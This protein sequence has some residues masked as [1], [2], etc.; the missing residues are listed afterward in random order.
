MSIVLT[1]RRAAL[2]AIAALLAAPAAALAVTGAPT[3]LTA[4]TPTKVKPVLTWTA[5]AAPGAGIAGYNVYRG[6]TKVN[7]TVIATTTYTDNAATANTSPSYT[8]KAVE[9]GTN[10]ESAASAAFV[11]VYDTTI[12]T[13]PTG[14]SATTPTNAAPV[15][16]WTASTDALSGVRRY[17]VLRGTTVLGTT[18]SLTYTDSTVPAAGSYSYSVKA[19]DWAGQ[20]LGR[21]RQ[22]GRVRQPG[23]DHAR[24]LQPGRVAA[25]EADDVV[26]GRHRHGRRGH[27]PLRGV[28]STAA[29]TCSPAAR[30][31]PASPTPRSR[32]RP[33]TR[34]SSSAVDKAGNSGPPTAVK[35]ITYDVTAPT[36]PA[37]LVASASPTGAK[38]A[39]AFSAATDTGGTGVASYRL[40]RDGAFVA[41]AA[42]T[43]V[44]GHGA[45][46]RRLLQLPRVGAR[47]GRQ[48]VGAVEPPSPS[49]TTRPRRPWRPV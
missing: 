33:P 35:S 41:T 38:P 31:R 16:T 4:T 3:G 39:L 34:T 19:E 44:V 7:A 47:R 18:S 45:V 48:R 25:D 32:P 12:P 36:V 26:D 14:V 20:P 42:G 37:G 30:P 21:R 29:P 49:S 9:T 2:V 11:V 22:D 10:L 5:P 43:T 6:A 27:R 1:F 8:V 15:L 23:A 46:G 24:R 13:T 40:Y 28:A 17:Q